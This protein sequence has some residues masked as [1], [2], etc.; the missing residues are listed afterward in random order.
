M[1]IVSVYAVQLAHGDAYRDVA[2]DKMSPS[3]RTRFNARD[4]VGF[5]LTTV[6]QYDK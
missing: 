4:P 5:Q 3:A 2:T 6:A 1:K